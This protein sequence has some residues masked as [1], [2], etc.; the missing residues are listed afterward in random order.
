MNGPRARVELWGGIECT[1]N[2]I[3]DR[4]FD[5]VRRSG[6]H[7]RLADL[8][9]FESLGLDAL[10]YP[11]L[12]ERVAPHGLA[13]AD[14]SWTDERLL[15]LRERGIRPI[16]G[17][18][19]HG[20]GP[21]DT[22]LIDPQ[23]PRRFAAYA[24]AVARR[25]PWVGDYTPVNEPLTT[26]RFSALYGHWYPH[27][28]DDRSF[29][30]ALLNQIEATALAMREIRKE[31]PD[32]RLVQTEDAGRTY[33]TVALARQARFE[34]DRRWLTF[35]LLAGRV[36]ETHPLR[37]W[38]ER[39]G[40]SP[41]TLDWL[42]EHPCPPSIVGL[43]YYLT[44]DRYLDE[45]VERYPI[46]THGGNGVQRYADVEAVRASASGIAGHQR[47]LQDAW[48]RYRLPVAI[49]E[50]HA[51]CT[52]EDQVRWLAE[53]WNGAQAA[54][55]AGVDARAVTAWALL[56]SFDWNS[57]LVR[58]DGVYEPGA[59]DLRSDPPRPTAVAVLVRALAA[60][61]SAAVPFASDRGWW[62]RP[63]RLTH[64]QPG[65]QPALPGR[66]CR[67]VSAPLVITGAGGTLG[68]ALARACRARGL[69]C[70][71][72]TRHDLDITTSEGIET[73]ESMRPWAVIN[74]AGYVRVDDAEAQTDDCLRLNLEGPVRLA[75]ACVRTGARFVTFSTDLVF[76]GAQRRPYVES[77]RPSPLNVYGMSKLE[78]EQRVL[79][80]APDALV[81]RTSAFFGPADRHNFLT[82]ALDA[83]ARGESYP[84]ASDAVVSP[85]YVPE[86][87]DVTL[88]LVLD[89]E[90]GVWHAANQGHLSWYEFAVAGA[91]AAGLDAQLVAPVN[92][93]Q[94]RHRATRPPF[95]ALTSERGLLLTTLDDAITRYV[96]ESGRLRQSVA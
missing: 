52:R 64:A 72:F 6:H 31:N 43:N 3:R 1:V 15:E 36:T 62:R 42:C 60:G 5:Q 27:G 10:R 30:T 95:S 69:E 89:G 46:H 74:A 81:I 29:V 28:R 2:R 56:G 37:R 19:H 22:S 67:A 17:L 68:S 4:Y 57:L 13:E 66:G 86:L 23:F 26:A 71:A 35:D 44:S 96:R 18:L 38:L 88:D 48:D 7:E 41:A 59:F 76:D 25:Y 58:D 61:E 73:L 53:A 55:D 9:L 40:A 24:A 20:S 32:A 84:A 49:T 34:N 91:R 11:V 80:L 47:V 87:A 33:S 92:A 90:R 75:S 50:A 16:A 21:A 45:R 54:S 82:I 94:L 14:W 77:D 83:L 78:A 39:A 8:D 51:G 93:E 63:D 79:A 85:T 70:R 65:P 12:W